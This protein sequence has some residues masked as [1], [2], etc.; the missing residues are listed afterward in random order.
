MP[1]EISVEMKLLITKNLYMVFIWETNDV[2]IVMSVM[3]IQEL[4]CHEL[5][6]VC[7]PN[8]LLGVNKCLPCFV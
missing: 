4:V 6:F 8:C 5:Q 7:T 1:S 2:H 3:F